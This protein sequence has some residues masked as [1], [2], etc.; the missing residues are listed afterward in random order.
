[1]SINGSLKNFR[2]LCLSGVI[3]ALDQY[4][5]FL[6]NSQLAYLQPVEI[7]SFFNLTLVYN[8][9]AAFSF[10][11]SASGWQ[12][13]FLSGIAVAVSG[14][15]LVW[16]YQL[17]EK[18]TWSGIALGAILGGAI[19]N[20]IDRL[21]RG[22]VIDFLDVHWH[23]YHWPVFNVADIAISIGAVLYIGIIIFKKE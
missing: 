1:M 11:H 9:G 18:D 3:I 20:L 7:F 17:S 19:A 13:W 14:V 10:L 21:V 5:K 6:A 22:Y 4:T 16:L 12:Q 8:M 23:Q 2:W 15:I